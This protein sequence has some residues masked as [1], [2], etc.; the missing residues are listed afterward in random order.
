MKIIHLQGFSNDEKLIYF[1]VIKANILSSINSLIEGCKNQGLEVAPEL[2]DVAN[3]LLSI[4]TEDFENDFKKLAIS[5]KLLWADPTIQEIYNM[6]SK[7][8]IL[9]SCKYFLDDIDRINNENYVPSE[10]DILRARIKTTGINEIEFKLDSLC[11]KIID[12]GGQR[13]ERRKWI[14]CFE[15]ITAVIFCVALSEYDLYLYEDNT[16]K[17]MMESIKLFDEI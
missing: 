14:N 4:S 13:S 17:R 5:V 8:Q 9:D 6:R 7:F 10:Q 12:V 1:T 3:Q 11:F 16:V 2:Q 15:G